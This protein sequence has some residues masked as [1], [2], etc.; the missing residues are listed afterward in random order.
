MEWYPDVHDK[1]GNL[2]T[3][4]SK[5]KWQ[6]GWLDQHNRLLKAA[7]SMRKCLPLFICGDLHNQAWGKI[8]KSRDLDLRVNPVISVVS[9]SLGTGPRGFPSGFRGLTAKPPTDLMVQEGLP[10]VEK[11][12]FVIVDF[13][14]EKVVIQFYA[15]KPPEPLEAIDTLQPYHTL[16]LKVPG[17]VG[18]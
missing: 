2:T 12:G 13:T 9:G 1:A 18:E 7:S 3:V 15:W 11:N 8:L 14:R 16:E 10:S 4:L 17:V 6:E 5:Y